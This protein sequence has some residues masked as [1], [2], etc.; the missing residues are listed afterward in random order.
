M[1]VSS[2]AFLFESSLNLPLISTPM[3]LSFAVL[4]IRLPLCLFLLLCTLRNGGGTVCAHRTND[5]KY[6]SC[7]ELAED[8]QNFLS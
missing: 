6:E 4:D 5:L 1:E 2:Q 8:T 3:L 7:Q